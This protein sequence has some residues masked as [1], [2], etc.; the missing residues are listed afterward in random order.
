[1]SN[2]I[3]QT[4]PVRLMLL[5]AAPTQRSGAGDPTLGTENGRGLPVDPC[6]HR[7]TVRGSRYRYPELATK[8]IMREKT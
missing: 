6:Q 4:V 8:T 1:M 3:N 2:F 7:Q 5:Q